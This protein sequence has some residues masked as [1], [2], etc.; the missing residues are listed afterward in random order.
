MVLGKFIDTERPTFM[1]RLAK[2]SELKSTTWP[3]KEMAA[4]S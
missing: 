1:D 2:T 4:K 3:K